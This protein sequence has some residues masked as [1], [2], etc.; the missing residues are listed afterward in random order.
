MK[1]KNKKVK[2]F[3]KALIL[4]ILIIALVFLV[5]TIYQKIQRNKFKKLLQDNDAFNYE[6]TEIVNEEETKVFVRDKILLSQYSNTR[7]WVNEL[8]SKRI[9]FDEEYKTA[10]I[11]ENDEELKV[12]SLNYTYI[13]NFFDNKEQKFKYCGEE[14]G[15]YKLQF[16]EKESKK[17]T[18]I[19]IN[20]K[21][22]TVDKMIQ[23]AGNFEYV[24]EFK[25]VKNKVSKDEVELP[26]LEGYRAYESVSSNPAKNSEN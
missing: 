11:D 1:I 18:L 9:V 19:Y 5:N 2:K 17:I 15:Y 6:L 25:V 4:I 3:L 10:I 8:E 21:T 20:K 16:E 14:D 12:N 23:N 13:E 26:N 7:T 24:T 22:N